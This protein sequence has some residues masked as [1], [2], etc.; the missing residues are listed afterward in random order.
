VD[1]ERED[2][3][4]HEENLLEQTAWL[5]A[6]A[7]TLVRDPDLAEDLAQETCVVA[8]ERPPRRGADTRAWLGTVLRNLLRQR[9]RSEARRKVREEAA[10]RPEVFPAAADVV[11]RAT[12]LQELGQAVME[13]A[14]PSRTTILMRFFD[15]L[16]PREIA[17][18][19]GVPVATV[20]SQLQRGLRRLRARMDA[21]HG[22]DRQAWSVALLTLASTEPTVAKSGIALLGTLFMDTNVKLALVASVLAA[23]G[24]W[25]AYRT[26]GLGPDPVELTAAP[27]TPAVERPGDRHPPSDPLA[28]ARAHERTTLASTTGVQAAPQPDEVVLLEGLVL[29]QNA[30]PRS[31][32][33]VCF[34]P[35]DGSPSDDW[36]TTSAAGGRI[37]M[38]VPLA[39]GAVR[40]IG[41]SWTNLMVGHFD[42]DSD[43]EPVVV[44]APRAHFTGEVRDEAGLPLAGAQVEQRLAADF[45]RD[46]QV[47][48]D[49]SRPLR[50]R[51]TTDDQG[52][53]E[54]AAAFLAEGSVL[55]TVLKGYRPDRR[56]APR[57]T[58][59]SVS[60]RLIRPEVL[61]TTVQG[62]VL[63]PSGLRVRAARVA[64]GEDSLLTD[65]NGAFRFEL[66]DGEVVSRLIAV[67]PGYLPGTFE[68]TM[69]DGRPIWPAFVELRLGGEPQRLRG[70]VLDDRDAPRAGVRVWVDDPGWFGSTGED[71]GLVEYLLAE[72][73]TD[74]TLEAEF[75]DDAGELDVDAFLAARRDL[76]APT[77]GWVATDARGRFEI[78]GLL[79]R[80]YSV[81]VFDM[82]TLA[83]AE[84]GP[85]PAGQTDLV[86]RFPAADAADRVLGS[87]RTPDGEPVAGATVES[88]R[89]A[90]RIEHPD[91]AATAHDVSGPSA[92]TDEQGQ[93]DLGHLSRE[94]VRLLVSGPGIQSSTIRLES[95]VGPLRLVVERE[96]VVER[97]HIQVE[98]L[99]P[100]WA[101]AFEVLDDQDAPVAL[102]WSR[103][104]ERRGRYRAD[105]VDGRSETLS[106]PLASSWIVFYLDGD[107]VARHVLQ[108]RAE[109]LNALRY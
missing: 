34:V 12:V 66:V 89:R 81:A 67:K 7:R 107:E 70:R 48:L 83:R 21:E 76:P 78:P 106:V 92:F 2:R 100:T 41:E 53:F 97:T 9:H 51:A 56:P 43:L 38:Q 33:T 59:A 35:Q 64:F 18:R 93:F 30:T 23:G 86:L 8:L 90:I 37:Q 32:I 55:D 5:R 91:G 1:A 103:V 62:E 27:P 4:I 29:D 24:L 46:F 19:A 87:V 10:A 44:V 57:S 45:F 69:A 60:I 82:D 96:V 63:D 73:I 102:I 99:D 31:S 25:V 22:G 16:P 52:H 85:F 26:V 80:R 109:S 3:V 101:D 39:Q 14:E 17:R 6:L 49:S 36:T 98:L 54:L 105:L 77:W 47:V 42:P 84:Y 20:N 58:P 88:L 94:R 104:S 15:D 50:A 13:L 74:E 61:E 95:S 79:H 65:E 68:P 28:P 11:A 108:L 75:T 72:A 71:P 40:A